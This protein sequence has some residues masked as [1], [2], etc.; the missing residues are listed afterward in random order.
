MK[1]LI[2]ALLIILVIFV[3]I[4]AALLFVFVYDNSR[5]DVTLDETFNQEKWTNG[6][7]MDSL[8]HTVSEK[9]IKFSITE[10]DINNMIHATLK[11]SPEISNYLTQLAVD[12]KDNSY[13]ISASGKFMFF[14]TRAKLNAKLSRDIIVSGASQKEALVFTIENLTLGKIT[15]LKEIIMFIVTRLFTNETMDS[16]TQQ[17]NIHFDLAQ[18]KMFIYMDDLKQ[19]LDDAL[20]S[21]GGDSAFFFTFINDFLEQNLVSF[22]FYSDDALS[23][24]VNLER[25][26]G[27][28]FGEGQYVYYRMDYESTTTNLIIDGQS[29]KLSLEIIKEALV[30]LMDEGLVTEQQLIDVSDYLF[31]GY[32][33]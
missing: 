5:M 6:L 27:N 10:E 11:D 31:N 4:P 21:D 12:I 15:K 17:L 30:T 28:D 1:K 19:L 32:V 22:D 24:S 8:D 3:V 9:K 18:S 2:K 26:T 20:S 23:I 16:L 14:E 33:T 7:I 25:L 13:E 29:K